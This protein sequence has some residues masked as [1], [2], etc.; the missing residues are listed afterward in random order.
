[1]FDSEKAYRHHLAC[2]LLFYRHEFVPAWMGKR[3]QAEKDARIR[4]MCEKIDFHNAMTLAKKLGLKFM[5]NL[6]DYPGTIDISPDRMKDS[7]REWLDNHIGEEEYEYMEG[8]EDRYRTGVW[9]GFFRHDQAKLFDKAWTKPN[10][11]AATRR[12]KLHA[13]A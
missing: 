6:W 5:V 7:V 13:V 8:E 11:F 3:R 1:M 4:T 12:G 9:I 2:T 10:R